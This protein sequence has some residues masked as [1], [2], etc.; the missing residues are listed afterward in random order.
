MNTQFFE[1]KNN[2]KNLIN[3]MNK[4]QTP[5]MKFLEYYKDGLAKKYKENTEDVVA[6]AIELRNGSILKKHNWLLNKIENHLKRQEYTLPNETT[7]SVLQQIIDVPLVASFLAKDP[8]K[9]NLSEI[10]QIKFNQL[11][12][13]KLEKVAGTGPNAIRILEG[14]IIKGN[15]NS[16]TTK[17]VDFLYGDSYVYAKVTTTSGGGQTNQKDDAVK[18]TKEAYGYDEIHG[19]KQFIILLDGDY[20]TPTVLKEFDKY[21][22]KNIRITNSDEF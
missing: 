9:Q 19:D 13:I 18:F 22:T 8:T 7:R 5:T 20:Y 4:I 10:L 1:Y 2:N 17:S 11:K 14:K 12:G 3:N 16:N 15:K 6:T 21:K